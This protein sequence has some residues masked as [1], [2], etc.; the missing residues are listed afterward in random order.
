ML[1]IAIAAT[2]LLGT[3]LMAQVVDDG[4]V[5]RFEVVRTTTPPVIDGHIDEAV[6][7]RAAMIDDFVVSQP[8]EGDEPS[9]YTQVYVLYDQ[10]ALYIAARAWDS[11][12]DQITARVL[13]QGESIRFDDDLLIILDP[14]DSHRSGYFF[15]INPNAVRDDAV[16]E[17]TTQLEFNWDGIYNAE[18]SRD[19]E[20]WSVE[21]EI[22]F[23]TISF[24]PD[25]ETWG[26]NFERNVAR[27]GE[28]IIWVARNRAINPSVTG[29][30]IGF[31]DLEQGRGLDIVPSVS[32]SRSKDFI[33]GATGTDFEPSLDVFY[34]VTPS[35]NASLTINTDF[36]ATEV[37]DRQVNL[38][39]FNLFFPEKRDFFLRDTDIFQF[40]R[41]GGQANT[42]TVDNTA[43]SRASKESGRPFFSRRIGLNGSGQP[44]DLNYGGKLSGRIGRWDVGGLS[45]RQD[46]FDG[47]DRTNITVARAAANVLQESS[48]GFIATDGNPVSNLDSATMGF[49]FRYLNSRL[50]NGR[51]LRADAWYL[52]TDTEGVT[53]DDSAFGL[54]FQ[55]PN[56]NGWRAGVGFKELEENYR[57]AL[58]FVDRTG[59]ADQT[60]SVGFTHRMRSGYLQSIYA[61][62]DAQRIDL[63]SGGLQSQA[64]A[65]RL[66]ELQSRTND[67]FKVDYTANKEVLATPFEISKGILIPSGNYSFDQYG[68][69][70]TT[71]GQ[72]RIAG[73]FAYRTGDFYG[74]KLDNLIG[75]ITWIANEHFRSSVSYDLN[76]VS[77]PQ[78]DFATRLVR[79]RLDVIFSVKW[80]WV[81]LIQYDNVSE[82]AGINSRLEWIPEAGREGFLVLNHN[83]EDFDLDNRF[84]SL[85][86]DI[87]L[88]FN[89]T[90]R[91]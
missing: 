3:G 85:H 20:G 75:E 8:N 40:G 68:F 16:F 90:I 7:Q 42:G 4:A 17:N 73:R 43:A 78:G 66:V 81:N 31:R 27:R 52:E 32:M 22:P 84:R 38:T 47:V 77:L 72:R 63:L 55:M 2:S 14:F 34:K 80:S 36:S 23:K 13:R 65:L 61:G 12:A 1:A 91:F 74:G 9:E 29:A 18:T 82:I 10:D 28:R 67:Q 44:V 11:Q 33:T 45:I 54:A 53:G 88:K 79:L 21:V 15:A 26:I 49:D 41:I 60:A 6:W 48:I 69:D 56:P 51:I 76:D 24:N 83:L 30:A 86:S 25:N 57:P 70:A 64:V 89:Y 59:I 5:K 19:D 62:A 71:A 37:D 50:A 46:G 39:R 35:L 58:G 87:A